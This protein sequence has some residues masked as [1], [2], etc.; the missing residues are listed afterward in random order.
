MVHLTPQ[1]YFKEIITMTKRNQKATVW[2]GT[3]ENIECHLTKNGAPLI[4]TAATIEYS[5]T[6]TSTDELILLYDN[7]PGG[8]ITVYNDGTP[9]GSRFS[10]AVVVYDPDDTKDLIPGDNYRHELRVTEHGGDS[11]IYMMGPVSIVESDTL[12][13]I[14]PS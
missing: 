10:I 2:Q 4:L 11:D 5:L 13:T 14:P 12:K 9:P 7:A 6:N 8:C 3:T 1:Q